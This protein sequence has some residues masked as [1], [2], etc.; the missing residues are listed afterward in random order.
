M[1]LLNIESNDIRIVGIHGLGGI[2][3]TTI[4]RCVYNTIYK[5]VERCSFIADARETFQTRGLVHLQSE[6]VT[7][8]LNLVNP[9]ITSVDKGI[10][11]IKQRL[12]NKKVLIVLDD[13]D[14]NT[15]LSAIIRKRDWFGFQSKIIITTRDKHRLDILEVDR[16]YEPKE[17]DSDQSL[18][19]FSNHAFKMDQPLKHYLDLSKDVVATT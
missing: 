19:L 17:M 15:D 9:N 8:I 1:K 11:V 18:Q 16:A 5:H 13:M 10:N 2:G 7:N 12:S 14:Q 3:K 4:A 6:L